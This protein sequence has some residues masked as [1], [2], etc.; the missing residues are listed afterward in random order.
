MQSWFESAQAAL[1]LVL[2]LVLGWTTIFLVSRVLEQR[3]SRK[4]PRRG[5]GALDALGWLWDYSNVIGIPTL[6]L[7]AG[8]LI[9]SMNSGPGLGTG[10][11]M[12]VILLMVVA[13]FLVGFGPGF[14]R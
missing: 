7:G 5:P 4:R 14:R 2:M 13:G 11:T 1:Q 10:P 8:Y 12:L 6:L 3:L 9:W